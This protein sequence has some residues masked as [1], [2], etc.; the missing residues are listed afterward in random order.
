MD[1]ARVGVGLRLEG[2]PEDG[3]VAR[4]LGEAI[5]TEVDDFAS[6][7]EMVRD[8]VACHFAEE[9]QLRRA[10]TAPRWGRSPQVGA[11]KALPGPERTDL[12]W[13]HP[14]RR[15]TEAWPGF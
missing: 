11:H 9:D 6:F 1:R 7:R 2:A 8:A 10:P 12:T 4:A 3:Y 5:F 15:T 13:K 14:P